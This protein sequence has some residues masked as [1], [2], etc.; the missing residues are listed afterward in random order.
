MTVGSGVGLVGEVEG[1]GVGTHVGSDVGSE[2]GERDIEGT[3]LGAQ[4]Y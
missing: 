1:E 3:R 2:V 4:E